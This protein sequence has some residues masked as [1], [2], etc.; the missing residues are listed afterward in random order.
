MK[1]FIAIIFLFASVSSF[2]QKDGVH[3]GNAGGFSEY[4]LQV[5]YQSYGE[6]LR[7]LQAHDKSI[8]GDELSL[9]NRLVSESYLEIGGLVFNTDYNVLTYS[10]N[11]VGSAIYV[12][13]K[14]LQQYTDQLKRDLFLS[15]AYAMIVQEIGQRAVGTKNE[16]LVALVKRI[17]VSTRQSILSSS[18]IYKDL[19][20]MKSFSWSDLSNRGKLIL[21]SA[22]LGVLDVSSAVQGEADCENQDLVSLNILEPSYIV[23]PQGQED[24][25]VQMNFYIKVACGESRYVK[26]VSARLFINAKEFKILS[27][28]SRISF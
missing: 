25:V 6:W 18:A 21:S 7:H 4:N 23:M 10:Q 8:Q 22:R 28:E 11:Q 3:V 14:L 20:L 13:S 27:I 9:L 2:A 24:F 5:A 12:N 15:E 19:D 17:E 1:H 26:D 16:N